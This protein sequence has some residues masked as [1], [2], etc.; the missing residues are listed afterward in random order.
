MGGHQERRLA[1][2]LSAHS[3][4]VARL[5]F[6]LTGDRAQARRLTHRV[7]DS[8][9]VRW[10]D[11][12]SPEELSLYLSRR[13]I[14]A[15]PRRVKLS[16]SERSAGANRARSSFAALGRRA[17]GAAALSYWQGATD[18]AVA[19]ALQCSRAHARSLRERALESWAR[20]MSLD[21]APH[22]AF[23]SWLEREAASAPP[24]MLDSRELHRASLL[25][26]AYGIGA[27]ALACT[28]ALGSVAGGRALVAAVDRSLEPDGEP[29]PPELQTDDRTQG[30]AMNTFAFCPDAREA[31]P[32]GRRAERDAARAAAAFNLA[33][34][35]KD[36]N[37][38]SSGVDE[39]PHAAALNPQ[40]WEKTST[41]REI[42]VTHSGSARKDGRAIVG[43]GRRTAAKS[44]K[45]V[46]R[47]ARALRGGEG[48]ASF[49][50]I[51]R[52]GGWRVWGSY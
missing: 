15:A 47:D 41:A 23:R 52:P 40:R 21:G 51:R 18:D 17:R 7:L 10:H 33:L 35:R 36:L 31:L 48:Y 4:D 37:A 2:T 44:W 24:V 14:R 42:G 5:A 46:L 38:I 43:C 49:Y 3:G 30:V 29:R 1:E 34:L 20:G 22:A 12:S 16:G 9:A 6:L 50:L 19:E 32:P 28:L 26:G 39:I 27:I 25:R 13:L 11:R 45:V 8:A